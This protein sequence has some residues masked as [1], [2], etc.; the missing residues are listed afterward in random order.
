[1][2][3]MVAAEVAEGQL[4]DASQLAMEAIGRSPEL[5]ADLLALIIKELEPVP[6]FRATAKLAPFLAGMTDFG[7]LASSGAVP[8]LAS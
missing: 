1:M 3:K 5:T 7:V 6:R 8:A 2:V 4:G